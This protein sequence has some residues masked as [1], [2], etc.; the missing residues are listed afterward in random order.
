MSYVFEGSNFVIQDLRQKI[1]QYINGNYPYG[2]RNSGSRYYRRELDTIK[3]VV[4][5]H[6]AGGLTLGEQGP[7]NTAAYSVRDP[8]FR[9]PQCGRS[10]LGNKSY[11]HTYCP[12][13]KNTGN[14]L[15]YGNGFPGMPYHVFVPYFTESTEQGKY[16]VYWCVDFEEVTWHSSRGN[17]QG[18]SVAWQGLFRSRHLRRF[19]P[20]P[21]TNGEPSSQQ[22]Q[23]IG[24]L[25]EEWL[26]P[27]FGLTNKDLTGHYA[28]EKPSCPGDF[29]ENKI[30]V[31]NYDP[32]LHVYNT[33]YFNPE[34]EIF[35]SWPARQAALV[36][37][38]YFLGTTGQLKNGVDG[39]PG[40]LTKMAIAAFETEHS[41]IVDGV[42][43]DQVEHAM[44][45]EFLDTRGLSASHLIESLSKE[46]PTEL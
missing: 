25:W 4:F 17:A 13:C 46:M 8:R 44:L 19:I 37:L 32:P 21:N 39:K 40:Q 22:Q 3:Y 29:L 14:N 30:R 45:F 7:I 41:L 43:D 18:V 34:E 16:V 27:N 36:I 1:D 26:R 24:P 2:W 9:C 23:L 35:G 12:V 20:W 11:P 38:G 10:W 15:G 42:W 6:T 33:T 5:H 31:I 28:F